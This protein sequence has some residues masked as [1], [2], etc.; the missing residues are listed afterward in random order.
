MEEKNT[1]QK[2]VEINYLMKKLRSVPEMKML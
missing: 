1:L 2:E